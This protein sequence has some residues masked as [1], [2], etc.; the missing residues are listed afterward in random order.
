MIKT[1][2][3]I[4][5]FVEDTNVCE[6]CAWDVV[7]ISAGNDGDVF[8]RLDGG[9]IRVNVHRSVSGVKNDKILA[10]TAS[11]SVGI[12]FII[13]DCVGDRVSPKAG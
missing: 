6:A 13:G 5:R 7:G 10:Q 8:N 3:V 9:V 11:I 1:L 12:T 4:E 2:A